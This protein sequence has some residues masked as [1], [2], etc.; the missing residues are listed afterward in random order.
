MCIRD[1]AGSDF[2]TLTLEIDFSG[3]VCVAIQR[4]TCF[5]E[6]STIAVV[7]KPGASPCFRHIRDVMLTSCGCLCMRHSRWAAQLIGRVIVIRRKNKSGWSSHKFVQQPSEL[8]LSSLLIIACACDETY[9][10]TK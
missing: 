4:D 7:N 3:A 9:E 8:S 2:C 6:L 5:T 10:L 1:R